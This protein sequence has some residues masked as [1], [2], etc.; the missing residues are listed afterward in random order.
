M[1]TDQGGVPARTVETGDNMLVIWLGLVAILALAGLITLYVA[2]PHRG[3]DI[4]HAGW[5]SDAMSRSNRKV[6]EK[7]AELDERVAQR[8]N[9]RDRD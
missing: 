7:L 5:L 3:E 1:G 9:H 2:F 8:A 4:P 6:I